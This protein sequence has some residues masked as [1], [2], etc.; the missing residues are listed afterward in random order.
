MKRYFKYSL[1]LHSILF[2]ALI[3]WSIGSPRAEEKRISFVILPKGTS[4]DAVL[5]KEVEE[6]M[7]NPDL[8]PGESRTAQVNLSPTPAPTPSAEPPPTPAPAASPT[9]IKLN[10]PAPAPTPAPTAVPEKTI[11]V[12]PK[13]T[14]QPIPTPEAAPTNTPAP[15][16]NPTTAPT[17]SPTPNAKPSATPQKKADKDKKKAD[18]TKT[19]NAKDAKQK[20]K[21]TPK[22]KVP[23]KKTPI[24]VANAYELESAEGKNRF[25]G[26]DLPKQTPSNVKV[27]E[28]GPDQE[29]G[30]PGVAEGVE[31]A[32]LPLDRNQSMLS[33]LYTTRARMKIQTN[34]TVP[35]GVDDPNMECVVEWEILPDGTI[36]NVRVKKSTGNQ[37][38]DSFAID[39]LNK[40]ANLGPL[41]PEFGRQ[42][43]W[44]S[45]TFVYAGDP[46][47]GA[48]AP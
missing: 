36:Q 4:L 14:P 12:A 13:G 30:V 45:L 44:T 40:T 15:T 32:P 48:T 2:G 16:A 26:S 27:G 17:K 31:G 47:P 19:P 18:A 42:S 29:V 5:T 3:L 38:Y 46:P 20:A 39:A 23:P 43:I 41:P 28:A 34:F 11:A 22:K 21:A 7:K 25:A 37:A 35:P 6:A 33:M 8:K 24:V 10:T 1:I 9:P